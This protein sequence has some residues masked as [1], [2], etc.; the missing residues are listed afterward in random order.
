[1]PS[2]A[3]GARQNSTIARR[4][5][6]PAAPLH[7]RS[8]PAIL[9]DA[10]LL[11]RLAVGAYRVRPAEILALQRA[12][13]NRAVAQALRRAPCTS[14]RMSI[15]WLGGARRRVQRY[16]LLDKGLDNWKSGTSEGLFGWGGR[17]G[18]KAVDAALAQWDSVKNGKDAK[19]KIAALD[20]LSNRIK[21][22]QGAK[23]W[24]TSGK[25]AAKLL[26]EVEEERPKQEA[27]AKVQA[28]IDKILNTHKFQVAVKQWTLGELNGIDARLATFKTTIDGLKTGNDY[29]AKLTGFN[30]LKPELATWL[31]GKG[32]FTGPKPWLPDVVQN[33]VEKWTVAARIEKN[34][35][36][37]IDQQAGIDA[38]KAQYTSVPAGE[39][40]KLKARD[41]AL[42]ELQDLETTLGKYAG[43]L[44]A[45]RDVKKFGAQPLTTFS[46]LEQAIDTNTPS[47]KLD[48]TTLGETFTGSKNVS[49]FD[50]KSSDFAADPTAPTAA[51]TRQGYRATIAH[52]L[53]H[54]LIEGIKSGKTTII[55]KFAT[56]FGFWNGKLYASAYWRDNKGK[57]IKVGGFDCDFNQTKAA[58]KKSKLEPPPTHYGTTTAKEDLAET[59]MLY[60]EAEAKLQGDCPK[61]HTFV[62]NNIAP[63]LKAP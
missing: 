13:G 34:Y 23:G 6:A 43:L 41:W 12:A 50:V 3:L 53:S 10:Q 1:V 38:I 21:Q 60:L 28:A 8:A 14:T 33:E 11:Q 59:M 49:M 61:R 63:L 31:T 52:E 16:E 22:W 40:N 37:K 46:R 44:G 32:V 19:T 57:K 18:Y 35:G 29:S 2:K 25:K 39:L 20:M 5:E 58:A 15:S 30:K 45:N 9:A 54:A 42:D 4:S 51:E 24:A 48:T 36:I 56:L 55:A 17:S 26:Q 47:G 27:Q 62:K 7:V